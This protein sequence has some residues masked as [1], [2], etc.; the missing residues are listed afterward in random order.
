MAKRSS[1]RLLPVESVW[2]VRNCRQ[3]G[4]EL[5]RVSPDESPGLDVLWGLPAKGDFYCEKCDLRST[6]SLHRDEARDLELA[7]RAQA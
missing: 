2:P 5:I 4:N 1:A 3:C 7:P 6:I